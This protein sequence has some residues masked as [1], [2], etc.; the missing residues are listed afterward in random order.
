MS[1]SFTPGFEIVLLTSMLTFGDMEQMRAKSNEAT[2]IL[3]NAPA[4]RIAAPPP[5][6]PKPEGWT[7]DQIAVLQAQEQVGAP[8]YF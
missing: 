8:P 2:S 6:P 1:C 4:V 3:P 7:E 5:P